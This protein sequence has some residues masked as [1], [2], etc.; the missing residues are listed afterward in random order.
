MIARLPG[1]MLLSKSIDSC[2]ED[3]DVAKYDS[4][5][6]NKINASGIPPHRLALKVGACIILIRNLSISDGHCNGTRCII[7]HLSKHIIKARDLGGGFNTEIIIPRI[8]MLSKE[9][10]F[11]V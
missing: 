10:D 8:P 3:D 2:V 11:P 1:E 6:L 4:D 9:T 7:V 5:Y